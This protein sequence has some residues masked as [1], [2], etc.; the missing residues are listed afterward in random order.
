MTMKKHKVVAEKQGAREP[1]LKRK[2]QIQVINKKA[3]KL[4]RR[5]VNRIVT[6]TWRR[7]F[8][9]RSF[10][11]FTCRCGHSIPHEPMSINLTITSTDYIR[12]SSLFL[13]W[14]LTHLAITKKSPSNWIYSTRSLYTG[15]LNV[16]HSPLLLLIL[17]GIIE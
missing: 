4:W 16:R 6:D 8:V 17:D 15:L 2:H 1:K 3:R 12:S 14:L 10:Y 9:A 13:I 7:T 11:C 5:F